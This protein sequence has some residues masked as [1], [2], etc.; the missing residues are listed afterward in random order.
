MFSYFCQLKAIELLK[1]YAEQGYDLA[2]YNISLCYK[3]K[4]ELGKSIYWLDQYKK[5]PN[6]ND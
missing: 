6:K 1:P 5:N 4:N 2:Q 3:D